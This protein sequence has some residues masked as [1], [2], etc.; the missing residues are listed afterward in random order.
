MNDAMMESYKFD[1]RMGGWT[2]VEEIVGSAARLEN[3]VRTSLKSDNCQITGLTISWLLYGPNVP[4]VYNA[5]TVP[6]T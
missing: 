6:Q 4:K 3:F 2:E 1:I 5:T